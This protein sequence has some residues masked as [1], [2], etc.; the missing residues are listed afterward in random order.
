MI[1]KSKSDLPHE[2]TT[3]HKKSEQ[4]ECQLDLNDEDFFLYGISQKNELPP[5]DQDLD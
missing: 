5:P 2:D 4:L 3:S 1:W